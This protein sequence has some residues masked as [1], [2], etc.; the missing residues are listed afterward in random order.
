MLRDGSAGAL[1]SL[2]LTDLRGTQ[3][4]TQAFI[5]VVGKPGG[6][7]ATGQGPSLLSVGHNT[8][9]RPLGAA[10]DWVHIDLSTGQ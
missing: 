2:G 7:E 3:G 4:R 8:D 1:V 5:V 9:T 6:L 10:L